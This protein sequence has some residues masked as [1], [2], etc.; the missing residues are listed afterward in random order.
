MALSVDQF[1]A[2]KFPMKHSEYWSVRKA[3]V[4][5]IVVDLPSLCIG[6]TLPLRNG[7]D[8]KYSQHHDNDKMF[9]H[10]NWDHH[11]ILHNT[12]FKAAIF[13]NM[14]IIRTN[15]YT[16][17]VPGLCLPEEHLGPANLSGLFHARVFYGNNWMLFVTIF[18][19]FYLNMKAKTCNIIEKS[20]I[21]H[22]LIE[23]SVS[24]VY[25]AST[26]DTEFSENDQCAPRNRD[27]QV[28]YDG[29][30]FL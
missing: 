5:A 3:K 18:L 14:A 22:F 4:L 30:F 2:L 19:F 1:F 26:I 12:S 11:H 21:K 17:Y 6:S 20:L 27:V 7:L 9:D 24:Y 29:F 16:L 28:N 25:D 13:V 23:F 15:S 10:D 8:R